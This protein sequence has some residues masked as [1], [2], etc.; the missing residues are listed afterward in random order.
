MCELDFL[1]KHIHLR[2]DSSLSTRI[3]SHSQMY[4][5]APSA[6]PTYDA[7]MQSDQYARASMANY[8]RS[9]D[10]RL[11]EFQQ[12]VNRYESKRSSMNE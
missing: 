7:T 1:A 3:S 6:P 9:D 11:G 8:R 2:L 5:S 12:V 4:A 10:E